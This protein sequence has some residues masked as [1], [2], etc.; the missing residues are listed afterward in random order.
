MKSLNLDCALAGLSIQIEKAYG[1]LFTRL[2]C[3]DLPPRHGIDLHRQS[4]QPRSALNP[5]KHYQ[6]WSGMA[7][8]RERRTLTGGFDK[9]SLAVSIWQT[10]LG[11]TI[12]HVIRVSQTADLPI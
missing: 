9:Q 4:L 11:Q 7:Y 8:L 12:L 6:S 5:F 3:C 2:M 1:A 10:K